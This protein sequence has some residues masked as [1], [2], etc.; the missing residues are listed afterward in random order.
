VLLYAVAT[1]NSHLASF[2]FVAQTCDF[3][4]IALLVEENR[5]I[6][7]DDYLGWDDDE[8]LPGTR[9]IYKGPSVWQLSLIISLGIVVGSLVGFV[10]GMRTNKRFNKYVRQSTFFRPI[11]QTK[12]KFVR[13]SL[14]LHSYIPETPHFSSE[15]ARLLREDK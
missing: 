4:G 8:Y 11:S 2:S 10:V 7:N 6:T 1:V 5:T 3:G 13:S 9:I 14:A 12:N 15:E